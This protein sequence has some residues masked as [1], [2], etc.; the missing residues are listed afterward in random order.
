MKNSILRKILFLATVLLA[1]SLLMPVTVMAAVPSCT[2]GV[3]IAFREAVKSTSTGRIMQPM[4]PVLLLSELRILE[5][6]ERELTR[7]L[8]PLLPVFRYRSNQ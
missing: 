5:V 7:K 2:V 1:I 3:D 6:W 8:E 4:R